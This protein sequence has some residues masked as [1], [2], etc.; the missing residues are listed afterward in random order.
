MG[1]ALPTP[2]VAGR[3]VGV[4]G[5]NGGADK[6]P[7]RILHVERRRPFDEIRDARPGDFTRRVEPWDSQ[8]VVIAGGTLIVAP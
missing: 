6:A 3:Q 4:A 2:Y 5:E 8:L 7:G 1:A